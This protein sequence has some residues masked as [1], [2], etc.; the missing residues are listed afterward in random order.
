MKLK[1]RRALTPKKTWSKKEEERLLNYLEKNQFDAKTLL[2]LFP[3]RKLP[4]IRSKVRKLRIKHDIFGSSYRDEKINFT[5]KVSNKVKPKI[6][7]EAYAGAGHQTFVWAEKAQV[8][9]AAEFSKGKL[10]LFQKE[11]KAAGYKQ[12]A[13]REGNW[14][15]F[16]KGRKKIFFFIGDAVRA[17]AELNVRNAKIDLLDLDTCGSTIPTLS[18][19]LLMLKPKYFVITHGEFHSM[20]FKRE[21]VLR[22]LFVHLNVSKNPFP[23]SVD[24]MSKELDKSVKLSALRSHNE[25]THS[26]WPELKDETWLGGKFHGMLRRYYKL[27]KPPA[28]ADCLNIIAA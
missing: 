5:R 11:A 8:V 16:R 10:R 27:K 20:R 13:K 19:Y 24:R 9:Y 21:D 7:F 3:K 22:R 6:V 15:V 25:T 17:A 28:T 1:R 12:D 4:S 26:Y 23:I 2:K 18:H 14:R